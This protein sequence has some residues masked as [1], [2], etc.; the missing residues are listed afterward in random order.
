MSYSPGTENASNTRGI[1][2]GG[3]LKVWI[4][5]RITQFN[6]SGFFT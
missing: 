1:P 5:Q 2:G 3:V 4:D 6:L